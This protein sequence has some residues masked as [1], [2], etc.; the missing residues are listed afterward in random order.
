M[1]VQTAIF[2]PNCWD[3]FRD[4]VP[5]LPEMFRVFLTSQP[6][7]EFDEILSQ[8][9]LILL[10]SINIL[11]PANLNDIEVYVLLKL[12]ELGRRGKLGEDW[13]DQSLANDFTRRAE[14]LFHLGIHCLQLYPYH[15]RSK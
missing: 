14:G 9:G 1:K 15:Y 12:K 4:Q 8:Q 10:R 3:I 5:K 2:T 7:G 13:P 6:K 11:A